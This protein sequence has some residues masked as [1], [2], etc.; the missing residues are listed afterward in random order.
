MFPAQVYSRPRIETRWLALRILRLRHLRCHPS[1]SNFAGQEKK[2]KRLQT[3]FFSMEVHL[4]SPTIFAAIFLSF[5][6]TTS[7]ERRAQGRPRTSTSLTRRR[8]RG[9]PSPTRRRCPSAAAK[10]R[11][12]HRAGSRRPCLRCAEQRVAGLEPALAIHCG[13]WVR[14]HALL[15]TPHCPAAPGAAGA[16]PVYTGCKPCCRL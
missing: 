1:Q 11:P 10:R 5:P 2:L 14:A 15:Q 3:D 8:C 7:V 6:S 13:P 9:P 12:R 16:L 4:V